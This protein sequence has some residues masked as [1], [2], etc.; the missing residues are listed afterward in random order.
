MTSKSFFLAVAA[1]IAVIT[2]ACNPVFVQDPQVDSTCSNG[3]VC[4]YNMTTYKS[5]RDLTIKVEANAQA[6]FNVD[7]TSSGYGL[8]I[9]SAGVAVVNCRGV[10]SCYDVRL[11]GEGISAYCYGTSS[12]Y[13][14][15]C[16]GASSKIVSCTGLSSCYDSKGCG[17]PPKT[18]NNTV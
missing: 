16:E 2:S 14:T 15:D 9:Q 18:L 4:T 6:L 7:Y 12:C 11:L 3:C 8:T 1:T 10:S 13:S 17:V 5:A